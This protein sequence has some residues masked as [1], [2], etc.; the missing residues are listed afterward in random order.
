MVQRRRVG[1]VPSTVAWSERVREDNYRVLEVQIELHIGII[2]YSLH[3]KVWP[4]WS[5]T[6]T[7]QVYHKHMKRAHEHTSTRAQTP[8]ERVQTGW[9]DQY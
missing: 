8:Q 2:W 3:H 1:G 5:K 6:W 9:L 7:Y 4:Q